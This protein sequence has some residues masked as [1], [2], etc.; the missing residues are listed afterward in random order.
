MVFTKKTEL[1][2]IIILPMWI[3]MY[4]LIQILKGSFILK[5]A[6]RLHIKYKIEN[7]QNCK[8]FSIK[9]LKSRC[10]Q[11]M[12]QFDFVFLRIE[13]SF[14]LDGFKLQVSRYGWFITL[15]Y[16]KRYFQPFNMKVSEIFSWFE[17]ARK[18]IKNSESHWEKIITSTN[19]KNIRKGLVLISLSHFSSQW[20]IM[21]LS[22]RFHFRLYG[23]FWKIWLFWKR[24]Y[25]ASWFCWCSV[26]IA[27][28]WIETFSPR[29]VSF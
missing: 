8:H 5:M 28:I 10:F 14:I 7:G 2:W 26:A 20:D 25:F 12:Y 17:R 13:T 27:Q 21:W 19:S 6:A 24:N 3:K 4:W 1:N 23:I 18:I 15:L 22:L 29:R 11:S 9:W 16:R